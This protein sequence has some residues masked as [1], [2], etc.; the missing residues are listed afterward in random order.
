MPHAQTTSDASDFGG[1][2]LALALIRILTGD[3][4]N[5]HESQAYVI[6]R[7][8][9]AARKRSRSSELK[10]SEASRVELSLTAELHCSFQHVNRPGRNLGFAHPCV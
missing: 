2:L 7:H 5:G 1:H 9:V 8:T 4:G 3:T 6:I 10:K